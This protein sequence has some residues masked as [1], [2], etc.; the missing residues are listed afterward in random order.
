MARRRRADPAPTMR[1]RAVRAWRRRPR[2]LRA[3]RL[4]PQPLVG[5]ATAG[6]ALL[7][8]AALWWRAPAGPGGPAVVLAVVLALAVVAAHRFPLGGRGRTKLGLASVP[9]YLMAALLPAPLAAVAAGL[10]ALGGD[11]AVRRARGLLAG[12][13]A[14][15]VGRRVVVVALGALAAHARAGGAGAAGG[16]GQADAL[17]LVAAAVILGVGD[18]A[19]APLV[20][21]PMGA[22]PPLRVIAAV[23]RDAA[24]L[25]GAQYLV[26]LL[27]ALAAARDTW[28]AGLLVV[29]TALVYLTARALGRAEATARALEHQATHDA[30][31]ALP[32]RALFQGRLGQ[33]LAGAARGGDAAAVLFLDLDRFKVVNDS[34]GHAAGDDLLVAVAGRLAGCVRGGDTVARL[35][36]DEFAVLLAG[37]G[38]GR[39]ATRT[40]GRIIRALDAPFRLGGRDVVTAT[41]IGIAVGGTGHAAADLLRDADVALYRAK[42]RGRGRYAV[43]DTAMNARA[44][45]RL[46]LEADL[47]RALRRGEFEVYY[48]PKV[49]L[50]TGCLAGLEALV[51]WRHPVRG[52]VGPGV[53]I[54]LAEETG[55]IQPLGQWVLEEACRQARRW[56][57]AMGAVGGG[58]AVVVSVNLSARQFAQ[59]TLVEDV[60][61]ALAAGGADPHQVQLEITEG[62]AMGNAEATVEILRRLKELGVGLAIDDFGTGYSSLAYLKR[63][64]VDALKIDRAFVTGLRRETADSSIVGAVVGLGRALRLAVVAE[65]VETAEEATQLCELGCAL[66]QGYHFARPLPRAQVDALLLSEGPL[67]APDHPAVAHA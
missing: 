28:A 5:A 16:T 52:V 17:A 60:A 20:L 49:D 38:V 39:E 67:R 30:L 13:I 32:N 36:G 21:S 47:R 56:G 40:A 58:A 6:C 22:G 41:S 55:L 37:L 64:P 12:D 14:S 65:G 53:F 3:A 54:P 7:A 8:L 46:E 57:E 62:V 18:I 25:E 44:L 2:R 61:R 10:G 4:W 31:T 1:L 24:P 26:G 66:G 34:L 19:T 23:A 45:E 9:Y 15:Q 63:F 42:A 35:G 48:Q 27:G 11:L 51:R 29:P 43:F 59:P 33:A 50:G